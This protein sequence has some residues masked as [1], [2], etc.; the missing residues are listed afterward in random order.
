MSPYNHA[1]Y[2]SYKGLTNRKA[3]YRLKPDA[4]LAVRLWRVVLWG[5]LLRH[6]SFTRDI[7]SFA[8]VFKGLVVEFDASLSG[9]GFLFYQRESDGHETCLGGGAVSIVAM[10]FG[11]NSALQNTAEFI[12]SVVGLACALRM[13]RRGQSIVL[14]G[15]SVSALTWAVGRRFR[16]GLASNAASV[17]TQIAAAGQLDAVGKHL[18]AGDN[19]RTDLLSRRDHWGE[20]GSVREI[21][22]GWGGEYAAAPVIDLEGDPRIV[23]LL[24]LCEPTAPAEDTPQ[25]QQHAEADFADR[26]ARAAR[27][28]RDLAQ[29]S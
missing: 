7:D 18:C 25:G 12:G 5:S 27:L 21:L 13:G 17:F 24:R 14:R 3:T 16:S 19:G 20:R 4:R 23:E 2:N 22:D 9:L 29:E 28:A 10:A 1:L 6:G 26:W 8:P 11:G 15:D